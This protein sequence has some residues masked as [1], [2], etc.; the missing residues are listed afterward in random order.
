MFRLELLIVVRDVE[1]RQQGRVHGRK[2]S[3]L[4]DFLDS[5]IHEACEQSEVLFIGSAL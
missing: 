2:N 4:T 3:T 5:L 1:R